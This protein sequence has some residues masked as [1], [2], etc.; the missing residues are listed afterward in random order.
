MTFRLDV[1]PQGR[2]SCKLQATDDAH[3]LMNRARSTMPWIPDTLR[4][5]Q[6]CFRIPRFIA[7]EAGA[8]PPN[9]PTAG[10]AM[11]EQ[12][13]NRREQSEFSFDIFTLRQ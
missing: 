1:A 7:D 12:P 4:R 11:N 6:D 3:M 13:E 8:P 10:G 5:I 9:R 2:R